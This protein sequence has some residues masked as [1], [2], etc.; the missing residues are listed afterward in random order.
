M[1][2]V[3][4]YRDTVKEAIAIATAQLL[5]KKAF[6]KISVQEIVTRA[7]VGRSSFYR[8][9]TSKEDVLITY[10]QAFVEGEPLATV[11]SR[12]GWYGYM[13]ARFKKFREAKPFFLALRRDHLLPLLYLSVRRSTK[14]LIAQF[15]LYS[16]AYQS[17]FFSSACVGV[18]ILWMENG[19]RESEEEL[20]GLLF[21]L[22]TGRD[23]AAGQAGERVRQIG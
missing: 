17:A 23:T 6:E 8:N 20:A 18:V 2:T 9:F 14:R 1:K 12:E 7:G 4:T 3:I 11:N 21:A 13:T 5:E 19:F 22:V 10:L 16:N 15:G